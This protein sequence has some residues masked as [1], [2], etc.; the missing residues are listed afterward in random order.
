MGSFG[1]GWIEVHM[2]QLFIKWSKKEHSLGSRLA[3]GFVAG[4]FFV[5]LIPWLLLRGFPSLDHVLELPPLHLGLPGIIIGGI[6]ILA[7]LPIGVWTV[8]DQFTRARGTPLPMMAT[9]RLLTDGP[10]AW[11]R[12]PM[13]FGTLCAYLGVS[14][15][16]GSWS[17]LICFLIFSVLLLAYLKL[18]EE[19]ELAARFGQEYLDY[20]AKSPFLIPWPRKRG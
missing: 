1:A 6:L 11:S 4:L 19:R 9:Q 14:L 12:N 16:A 5:G 10:Y 7:G 18:I 15:L 2:I 20:K 8:V 3:A 17:T 13:V